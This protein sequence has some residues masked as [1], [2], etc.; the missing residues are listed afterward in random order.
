MTNKDVNVE[1]KLRALYDLQL[2]DSRIDEIASMRGELPLEV[3]DLEDEIEGLRTRL[4]NLNTDI[5]NLETS[6]ANKKTAIE[7]AKVMVKKY[8][9]QQKNVRN[10][11]EFDS[12]TKEIEYQELEIQLAEKKIKEAKLKIEQKHEIIPAAKEKLEDKENHLKHKKLELDGIMAETQREGD[13]LA[14]KSKEFSEIIDE[15]L[16]KAYKK[17]RANVRNGLAIVSIERGA[18]GGSFFTIP[19]QRQA[20]IAT[21]KKI[22]TDEHSG[23]ILIDAELAAE[24]RKKIESLFA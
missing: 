10:N 18:S 7:D 24:E 22:I 16:L 23:R 5:E 12:L 11:R 3:K 6:I 8:E 21:R 13:I 2:I 4:E 1:A 15:R 17:I 19:P 20:E 14:E 9:E